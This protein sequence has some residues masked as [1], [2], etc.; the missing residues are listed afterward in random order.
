MQVEQVDV[1]DA[2]SRQAGVDAEAQALAARAGSCPSA[3][4]VY[5][6][7]LVAMVTVSRLS[8]SSFARML[9]VAPPA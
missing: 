2:E 8:A 3:S 9:S 6:P 7:A 4:P 1:V 5:M